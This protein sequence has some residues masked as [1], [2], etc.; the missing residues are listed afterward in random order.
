MAI[1]SYFQ[2][3][4]PVESYFEFFQD[5][6]DRN[7]T[8]GPEC[9]GSTYLPSENLQPYTCCTRVFTGCGF[10]KE[11]P[12]VQTGCSNIIIKC[13]TVMHHNTSVRLSLSQPGR[14]T[15]RSTSSNR[16]VEPPVK[17]STVGSRAFV[18]AAPH[19]WNRL[20]TDVTSANSL[21]TF[22]RLLKHFFNFNN[23][24]RSTI[25]IDILSQ[26]SLQWLLHLGHSKN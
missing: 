3:L 22:R 19:I 4:S 2:F 5:F 16:L 1:Y 18:F 25:S 8:V 26:W 9:G 15:L 21:L 13:S 24:S 20:P 17:L 14:R 7:G 6:A 12:T 11:Q 23:H 10:R